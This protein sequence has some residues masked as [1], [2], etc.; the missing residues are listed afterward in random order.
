[1]CTHFSWAV[2][3]SCLPI[4]RVRGLLRSGAMKP[5]DKPL[6]YDVYEAFPP[7]I[8]PQYGRKAP[9]IAIR[10]ILYP[11]DVIRA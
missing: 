4:H 1:M 6:W 8:E 10:N 9:D 5:E 3:N 7:K 2:C 11:E